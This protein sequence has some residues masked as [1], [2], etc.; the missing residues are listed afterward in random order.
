MIISKTHYRTYDGVIK[1]IPV[2]WTKNRIES[3][4]YEWVRE[5][6]TIDVLIGRE[7]GFAGSNMV[8][9]YTKEG[10]VLNTPRTFATIDEAHKFI[11]NS[12]AILNDKHKHDVV[13]FGD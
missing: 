4:R 13:W 3:N 2:Q 1:R 9:I 6:Y 8:T 10:Y 11:R 7:Q 12:K 5:P